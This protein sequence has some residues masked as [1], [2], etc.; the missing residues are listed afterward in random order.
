VWTSSTAT[1]NLQYL[2]HK[3]WKL[4]P[5]C[6][7]WSLVPTRICAALCCMVDIYNTL[8]AQQHCLESKK[9]FSDHKNAAELQIKPCSM[10]TTSNFLIQVPTP[11]TDNY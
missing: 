10:S 11:S 3:L 7:L 9:Y 8:M 2:A 4:L 6:F 5:K 1:S